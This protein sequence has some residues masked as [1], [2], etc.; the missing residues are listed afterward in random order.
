MATLSDVTADG[1]VFRTDL[2]LRPD[3][4]VTPVCMAMATAEH[5]YEAEVAPGN[6]PPGSRPA[7]RQATLQAG[8]RSATRSALR[9]AQASGLCRIQDAHDMR[10]RIRDHKGLGGALNLYATT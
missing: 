2:R 6:A 3:A 10:L 8:D 9:L 4:A 7:Q 5:Y 1:Y